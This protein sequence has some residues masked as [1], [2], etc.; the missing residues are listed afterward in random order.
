MQ[1]SNGFLQGIGFTDKE[2]RYIKHNMSGDF[3][4]K[5]YRLDL[6]KG[7]DQEHEE[8]GGCGKFYLASV[9]EV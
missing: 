8:I 2:I 9:S 3:S 4:D 6:S 1:D 7:Y 5:L